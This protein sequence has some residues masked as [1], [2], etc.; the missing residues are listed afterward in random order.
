MKMVKVARYR[1]VAIASPGVIGSVCAFSF[2]SISR[3]TELVASTTGSVNFNLYL[4]VHSNSSFEPIVKAGQMSYPAERRGG[5]G[6]NSG[7]NVRCVAN[8]T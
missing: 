3:I 6:L 2:V 4:P 8:R 5:R 1:T 7:K